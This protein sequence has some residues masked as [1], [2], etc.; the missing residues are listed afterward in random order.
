ML[1]AGAVAGVG[2]LVAF[3]GLQVPLARPERAHQGGTLVLREH[4]GRRLGARVKIAVLRDLGTRLPE[5]RRIGTYNSDSNTPHGG[6]ER[7]PRV[8]ARRAPV[9][10]VP[11]R[12]TRA[13]ASPFHPCG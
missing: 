7:G 4:R 1:S 5:V 12:L 2:R 3:T 9:I 6:G 10:V 13:R 8:P 11:P